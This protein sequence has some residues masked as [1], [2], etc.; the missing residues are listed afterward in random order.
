MKDGHF[1]NP[2]KETFPRG[3]PIEKGEMEKFHQRR[4]EMLVWLQG[5]TPYSKKIDE[6]KIELNW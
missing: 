4:E 5:E 2:L 3:F 1:R 6:G